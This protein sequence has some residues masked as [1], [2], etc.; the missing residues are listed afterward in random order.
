MSEINQL[1]ITAEQEQNALD[2][3]KRFNQKRHAKLQQITKAHQTYL[4][5][6]PNDVDVGAG[7]CDIF[8]IFF[9]QWVDASLVFSDGTVSFSGSDWTVGAIAADGA[10]VATLL[11][12]INQIPSSGQVS[13]A[14]ASED[15]GAAILTFSDNYGNA[16]CQLTA[17]LDGAGI[18]TPFDCSGTFTV[19]TS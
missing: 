7:K 1:Q 18:D 14:A 8:A 5:N 2:R 17:V 10:G 13:V 3:A 4:A 16:L 11:V 12:P 6:D 9:Y 19:T 15:A